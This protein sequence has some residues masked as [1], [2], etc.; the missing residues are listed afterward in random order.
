MNIQKQKLPDDISGKLDTVIELLRHIL[1]VKLHQG[2]VP[3]GV[4]G[5]KLHIAKSS[6]VKM[7]QGIKKGK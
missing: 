1:A 6:V 4:I 3:K 5:K 2:N 7:L